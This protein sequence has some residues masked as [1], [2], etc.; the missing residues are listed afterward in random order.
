MMSNS[1]TGPG[2]RSL[3]AK[4]RQPRRNSLGTRRGESSLCKAPH[5]TQHLLALFPIPMRVERQCSSPI[6]SAS[7][8]SLPKSKWQKNAA[9]APRRAESSRTVPCPAGPATLAALVA[10]LHVLLDRLKSDSTPHLKQ[11]LICVWKHISLTI[12][13]ILRDVRLL[14]AYQSTTQLL[15]LKTPNQLTTRH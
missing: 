12:N 10:I 7:S 14:T 4:R 9:A 1:Q 15:T 5:Q 8:A 3:E 13:I 2:K 6:E 11:S